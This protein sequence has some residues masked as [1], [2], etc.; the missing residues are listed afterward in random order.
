MGGKAHLKWERSGR[1]ADAGAEGPQAAADDQ[2]AHLL[3]DT[4]A[5]RSAQAAEGKRVRAVA[6]DGHVSCAYWASEPP[7]LLFSGFLAGA[8]ALAVYDGPEKLWA[9]KSKSRS[10]ALQSSYLRSQEGF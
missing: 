1:T 7:H 3:H 5:L 8:K 4:P 6:A 10:Q 9:A 2:V